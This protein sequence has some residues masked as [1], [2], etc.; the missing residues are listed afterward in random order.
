M[1]HASLKA[2]A[3]KSFNA[4]KSIKAHEGGGLRSY[5]VGVQLGL[6]SAAPPPIEEYEAWF[7]SLKLT[8]QSLRIIDAKKLRRMV[9]MKRNGCSNSEI[10]YSMGV[11]AQTIN[12]WLKRLPEGLAA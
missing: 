9:T 12:T 3:L 10:A 1:K 5:G 2:S 11:G 4:A 7:A 8:T 6:H